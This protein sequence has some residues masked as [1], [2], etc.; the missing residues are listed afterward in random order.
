MN[1]LHSSATIHTQ[2]MSSI[3]RNRLLIA[4]LPTAICKRCD[5]DRYC[6]FTEWET[7]IVISSNTQCFSK[8]S[9]LHC[10]FLNE[11]T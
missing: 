5:S 9:P 8:V 4:A 1:L 11:N 2:A 6:I 10:Y 3:E 7:F